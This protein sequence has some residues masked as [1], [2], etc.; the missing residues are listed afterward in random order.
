MV[1][2]HRTCRVVKEV[3]QNQIWQVKSRNAVVPEPSPSSAAVSAGM[4]SFSFSC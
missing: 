3:V 1:F 2:G 4:T